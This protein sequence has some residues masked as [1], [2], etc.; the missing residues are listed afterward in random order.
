MPSVSDVGEAV[1]DVVVTAI[2]TAGDAATAV[3]AS[4]RRRPKV[5]IGVGVAAAVFLLAMMLRRRRHTTPQQE[6]R[7]DV[8][9][10]V[11]AA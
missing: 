1:S 6:S 5:A 2:D 8:T 7:D 11:A 10:R 3:V 4:A 9:P